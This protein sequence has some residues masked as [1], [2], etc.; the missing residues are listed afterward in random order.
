[1]WTMYIY[2][3]RHIYFVGINTYIK[4]LI[5]FTVNTVLL[6]LITVGVM[7]I[8]AITRN[9]RHSSV[10]QRTPLFLIS[11]YGSF[12]HFEFGWISDI[13]FKLGLT[14]LYTQAG[15]TSRTIWLFSQTQRHGRLRCQVRFSG[16]VASKLS[17]TQRR[18]GFKNWDRLTEGERFT[19]E[20]DLA[21]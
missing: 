14:E 17:Q 5:Y 13:H 19:A 6:F 1:M 21:A 11:D 10:K 12:S 18:G 3:D 20:S 8:E 7:H 2:K 4:Y 9:Y 15:R 16:G